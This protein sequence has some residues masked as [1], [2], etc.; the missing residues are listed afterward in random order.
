MS[1]FLCLSSL[2]RDMKGSLLITY[3]LDEID[4]RE[5][6][7]VSALA[8]LK[9]QSTSWRA[10]CVAAVLVR[11]NYPCTPHFRNGQTL[12]QVGSDGLIMTRS[13]QRCRNLSIMFVLRALICSFSSYSGSDDSTSTYNQIYAKSSNFQ[14]LDELGTS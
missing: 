4:T 1:E 3:Y 2:S 5:E 6:T 12:A 11:R 14:L 7:L 9:R 10:L 13:L 8:M